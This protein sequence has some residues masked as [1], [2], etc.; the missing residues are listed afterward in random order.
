MQSLKRAE[1]T[2]GQRNI[3][4]AIKSGSVGRLSSFGKYLGDRRVRGAEHRNKPPPTTCF[5][6]SAP[7]LTLTNQKNRLDDI[8]RA[9]KAGL[10]KE[11][12]RMVA[13]R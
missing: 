2:R 11:Q 3:N 5:T 7:P 10:V 1:S 4:Q 13:G 8:L 6:V 9:G 12:E